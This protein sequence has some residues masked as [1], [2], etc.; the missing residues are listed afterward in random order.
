MRPVDDEPR[1]AITA[2]YADAHADEAAGPQGQALIL[3]LRR[4]HHG[5]RHFDSTVAH[6]AGQHAGYRLPR[7]MAPRHG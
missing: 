6:R 7:P 3:E 5:A 1:G 4:L 2:A